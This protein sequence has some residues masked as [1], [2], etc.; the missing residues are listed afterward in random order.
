MENYYLRYRLRNLRPVALAFAIMYLLFSLCTSSLHSAEPNRVKL[1]SNTNFKEC[2]R[3]KSLNYS[4]ARKCE[5]CNYNRFEDVYLQD[6]IEEWERKNGRAFDFRLKS[7]SS[8]AQYAPK[9]AK[10]CLRR[11]AK[12]KNNKRMK[13]KNLDMG[14]SISLYQSLTKPLD[15]TIYRLRFLDANEREQERISQIMDKLIE[16]RKELELLFTHPIEIGQKD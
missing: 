12:L 6:D 14:Y 13:S 15:L 9:H 1:C 10:M 16:C 4:F 2:M 5:K 3:C 7:L 11:N 8:L